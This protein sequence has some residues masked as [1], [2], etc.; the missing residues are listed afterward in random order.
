MLEFSKFRFFIISAV[1]LI[2]IYFSIPSFLYNINDLSFF[3]SKKINFGLDLKGGVSL[4]IEA[5]I[6]KYIEEKFHLMSKKL[7]DDLSKKNII[8]K[9]WKENKLKV[10]F[11]LVDSQ[12]I[13]VA[14]KEVKKLIDPDVNLNYSNNKFHIYFDNTYIE[15][16]SS[17]VLKQSIEII[18]QRVDAIGTK[19]LEMQ[20]L[21]KDM[22]L[23]QVPGI[24]DTEE[25]KKI[26]GKTARLT[27]H[28]VKNTDITKLTDSER[29][30]IILN[31]QIL[32]LAN[33]K[34]QLVV[35]SSHAM[36]GDMLEDVNVV[37]GQLGEPV[38]KFRLS[39]LGR[40]IFSDLTTKNTGK[41]LAI[42]L[43]GKIISAPMIKDPILSGDGIIT[44]DFSNESAT[45][46]VM[47]LRSGALPI[48]LKFVE[49]RVV[50]PT[51]GLKAVKDGIKA[52]TVGAILVLSI[53]IIYYK[54]FGII[55]NI[56]LLIN[57]FMIVSVMVLFDSTLTLPGIAGVVLTLGM[58]VD[59][60]V[61]I[62][63]RI[64]EELK[65]GK[66]TL[67]AL[68]RGYKFAFGT[69]LDSNITTILAAIVLYI[70]GS[71]PIKGFAITL[72]IGILCSMFTSISVTKLLITIWYRSKKPNTIKK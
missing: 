68:D 64:K 25:I 26:I 54:F 16:L 4:T 40:E 1:V 55:A 72:I 12:N 37:Q 8:L 45:E 46:L 47:L 61:L 63:E 20:T 5:D 69:I 3:P 33:N 39:S 42:V 43:D 48:P 49:E 2:S 65:D 62:F 36:S 50:G 67:H 53:M 58:A 59:A 10:E 9:E 14:K 51:L 34:G 57:F 11:E 44:G 60:N 70:F 7:K 29:M 35:D 41:M 13:D 52:C 56:A 17:E 22:I 30:S 71:G 66:S 32:P 24:Y 19:E 31:S 38:I 27:F 6:E 18:N 15:K 23:L 21:G 28:M